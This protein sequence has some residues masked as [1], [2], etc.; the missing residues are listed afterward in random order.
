MTADKSLMRDIFDNLISNALKYTDKGGSIVTYCEQN[1]VTV[2][3]DCRSADQLD[4]ASLTEPFVKG[5]NARSGRKGSGLG[6]AIA[7]EAAEK[8]GF[9]LTVRAANGRFIAELKKK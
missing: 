2:S 6:L 9:A 7:T 1:K 4:T 8:Q 5:D 3:N